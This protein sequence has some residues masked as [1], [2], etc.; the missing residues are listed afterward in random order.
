MTLVP[1]P[2]RRPPAPRPR[3]DVGAT[4][5][6]FA[7][8]GGLL[9]LLFASVLQLGMVVHVRNTLI[10]C[11]A[12]GARLG[13]RADRDPQDGVERARQLV[14]SELSGSY[15]ARIQDVRAQRVDRG[16]VQVVEVTLRAPLPIVGLLGPGGALTVSGHAYD[17]Q[18]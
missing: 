1:P 16:G 10:D 7:L 14:A 13:A 11:A 18:Q 12:E 3:G 17:E 6:D 15:A 2:A 4:V 5:V 8:V 9:T